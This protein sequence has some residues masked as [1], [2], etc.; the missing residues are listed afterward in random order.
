MSVQFCFLITNPKNVQINEEKLKEYVRKLHVGTSPKFN[1]VDEL[2][3]STFTLVKDQQ[4]GELVLCLQM[5]RRGQKIMAQ[6]NEIHEQFKPKD[7]SWNSILLGKPYIPQLQQV[8]WWSDQNVGKK[9]GPKWKS[10]SWRGPYFTHIMEPYEQL[11]ALLIYNGKEYELEP[12]EEEIA[13]MYAKKLLS[14]TVRKQ[15]GK[16]F[17]EHTKDP[18]FNNNF[19]EDFKQYLTRDHRKIFT[20]FK[21]IDWSNLIE[22][23]EATSTGALTEQEKKAKKQLAVQKKAEYGYAYLNGNKEGLRGFV[24]E[25]A[26][27]FMGRGQ[28]PLRGKIK[29]VVQPEDVTVN[30]GGQGVKP[31]PPPV[32]HNWG[33]VISNPNVQ[34]LAR[35]KDSITGGVKNIYF[36]DSGQFKGKSDLFKYDKARKLQK[37]INQ[38]RERY[39]VDAASQNPVKKQLGT[40]LWLIDNHGIRPGDEKSADE[41]DTVGASTLPVGA[42]SFPNKNIIQL[43]FIGKDSINYEKIM[44]VPDYIFNN[45]QQFI[46]GKT[47]DDQLFDKISAQSINAYLKE[48][49]TNFTSKVF[50]TRLASEIMYNALKDLEIPPDADRKKIKALFS[51]ANAN[52]AKVLNHKKLTGTV[53][54]TLQKKKDELEEA[55]MELEILYDEDPDNQRAIQKLEKKIEGLEN[56]ITAQENV[57]E[58]SIQTSLKNYIDPRIVI[59]W[60]KNQ[61]Q[62][63]GAGDKERW[64]SIIASIYTPALRTTFNWAFQMTDSDWDWFSSALNINPNLEPTEVQGIGVAESPA[65]ARKPVLKKPSFKPKSKQTSLST[66]ST[67][68]PS[69]VSHGTIPDY[70]NLEEACKLHPR[71]QLLN[72]LNQ[73]SQSAWKSI[74]PY[75]DYA[76]KNNINLPVNKTMKKYYDI[77]MSRI[78]K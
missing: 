36:D 14:D 18:L 39:T 25:P 56:I 43:S 17:E 77:K 69:N 10:L 16:K 37:Y 54:K 75:V 20:D 32:G 1:S 72:N 65:T 71:K 26:G 40:V 47:K 30:F 33:D 6:M 78:N 22:N 38:V 46:A 67:V 60:A 63:E 50:R 74:I 44:E 24:V 5:Q 61:P 2:P 66:P 62:E 28:H 48:D 59:A 70:K 51:A 64:E 3:F 4:S 31:P 23:V 45:M 12:K 7:L 11:G 41:A 27:I 55:V 49:D 57:K 58:V 35:Y 8:D 29:K 34:W 13:M 21:K 15:E 9:T 68:M 52:I 42:V 53:S 73:V 76:I 19:F